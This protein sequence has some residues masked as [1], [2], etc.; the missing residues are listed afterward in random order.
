MSN[1]QL[2]ISFLS[3][4]VSLL[5]CPAA[6]AQTTAFTYQGRLTDGG[7]PANGTYDL[8]FKLYDAV[9]DGNLQGSPNTV[10]KS[11]VP[12]TNGMFT[13]QLDFGAGAFPG[14]DRFLDIGVK[15]P[16]DSSYSPLTPRQP[17]SSTP[18]AIKS[19]NA[20][21]AD[22][23]TNSTQL[24]GIAASQYVVTTDPRMNDARTPT[25]NSADYIQNNSSAQP[26]N[27]SFNISGNGAVGSTLSAAVVSTQV[28]RSPTSVLTLEGGGTLDFFTINRR[29]NAM[30]EFRA[31]QG[32]LTNS[33]DS[34]SPGGDLILG[35]F[36]TNVKIGGGFTP[37]FSES[38]GPK[39]NIAAKSID[40]NSGPNPIDQVRI[41]GTSFQGSILYA[42]TVRTN[43]LDS[44]S[45]MQPLNIGQ[46]QADS[47][48]IH[49]P[50]TV[51]GL[52]TANNGISTNTQT[53]SGDLTVGGTINGTVANASNAASLGGVAASQYVQ[54]TDPRMSDARSPTAG[55]DNYIQNTSSEQPANFNISGTG[56]VGGGLLE[57]TN[58]YPRPAT[59]RINALGSFDPG[60]SLA[61]DGQD[62]WSIAL[63][64][65]RYFHIFN[66]ALL[67]HAFSIDGSNNYV[68]IGTD[69]PYAPF[70][71]AL[72]TGNI[73]FGTGGCTA[74]FAG[75]GFAESLTCKNY[76]LL[77]D[78]TN[79][80]INRSTGGAIAFR[81]NNQDQMLVL[82]GGA[83]QI[84]TLG[85][86]GSEQ[87][88][89]N[90]SKEIS[91][92]SSSLRYKTNIAPFSSGLNLIKQLRPISFDWKQGGRKDVGFGAEDVA[93][94]NP[95]F[96]NY[97]TA[98]EVEGV[99][100]DRL[101]AVFVNA[102][103]EQQVQID[104]Q[105]KLIENQQRQI[106]ALQTLV[107]SMNA[108][109]DI[110]KKR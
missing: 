58:G 10:T 14:A 96:V 50:T 83:I 48:R 66:H 99:K 33:V 47:V 16:T 24:N 44:Y 22:T 11:G 69:I 84:N 75:L 56:R 95:L 109:A 34:A 46:F 80:I 91:T 3:L 29:V 71:V 61:L 63:N 59:V 105:Q 101:S 20:V 57:V 89:R 41:N 68:G 86:A 5:C 9:T 106:D 92:C 76:S 64:Q 102:F 51:S 31:N 4:L 18:Y 13:L 43:S 28:L 17:L 88:C 8:Q 26:Q 49:K 23:A 21:N 93:R 37:L 1:K 55:S 74:G 97:N 27:S 25:A 108:S 42:P 81:E 100:Y 7:T 45:F 65:P 98:G 38:A 82:P 54:T 32:V 110:C 103:K 78:G 77:G 70:H 72:G 62:K 73:L 79:T 52:F 12:V 104:S 39:V 2:K 6:F 107:C 90:A 85:A 94:I 87:L 67:A 40:I 30:Q 35:N 36:A 60:I 53:I 15:K 19:L